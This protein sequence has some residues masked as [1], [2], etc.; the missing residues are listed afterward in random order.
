MANKCPLGSGSVPGDQALRE[1]AQSGR[2]PKLL[3]HV[4][5]APC[6]SAVLERLQPYFLIT[7]Y[8]DNP[9][10]DTPE[11]HA[12]RAEEAKR[13]AE[14]NGYVQE[15]VISPYAPETFAAA[16]AG[17]HDAPEG[18]ER[19]LACY[20]LR[21]H[22][23]ARYAARHGFDW[24]ATTL[25]ISPHKN[26]TT[27]NA[28]GAEAAQRQGVAFLQ[29]DFK[30]RGGFQRSIALS[31]QFGLYRQDYCGCRFS[32]RREQRAGE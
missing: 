26:A 4:C 7:M 32:K 11:E 3:L 20:R 31:K 14:L 12:K 22:N 18:G 30:K 16:A 29:A 23:S 15:V 10:L 19:C 5:C 17:L 2:R 21:L 6:S 8:F 28:I 25:S 9:N 1:I 13:L 24:L 27:L